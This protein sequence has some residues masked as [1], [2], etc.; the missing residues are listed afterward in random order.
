MGGLEVLESRLTI[1]NIS[2]I[3]DSSVEGDM[4]EYFVS[5]ACPRFVPSLNGT[6]LLFV[7]ESSVSLPALD[8]GSELA[9]RVRPRRRLAQV[10]IK[11]DTSSAVLL[12]W[13]DQGLPYTAVHGCPEFVPS[14]YSL[15]Q[16]AMQGNSVIRPEE[17][18]LLDTFVPGSDWR[19]VAKRRLELGRLSANSGCGRDRRIAAAESLGAD[20]ERTGGSFAGSPFHRLAC[21]SHRRPTSCDGR[22]TAPFQVAQHD[23]AVSRQHQVSMVPPRQNGVLLRGLVQPTPQYFQLTQPWIA[24]AR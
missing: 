16:M 19:R 17:Q 23:G 24:V 13:G 20:V 6:E 21:M 22:V 11:D 1:V 2:A 12:A 10:S 15:P 9:F 4:G 8:D 7:S 3:S 5:H 18:R 14:L